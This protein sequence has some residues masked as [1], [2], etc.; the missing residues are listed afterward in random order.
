[1]IHRAGAIESP[2][3]RLALNV[4]GRKFKIRVDKIVV[5]N[6]YCLSVG[7]VILVGVFFEKSLVI[8]VKKITFVPP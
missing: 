2:W 7:Y 1:M 6:F 8:V 4:W 3:N 5:R